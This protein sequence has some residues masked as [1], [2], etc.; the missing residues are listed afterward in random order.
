MIGIDAT[1]R[2]V[3]ALRS[4]QRDKGGLADYL[5]LERALSV[6]GKTRIL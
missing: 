1:D 2:V 4:I 3:R 5:I 6:V